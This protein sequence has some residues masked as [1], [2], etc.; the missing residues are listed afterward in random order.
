V[1]HSEIYRP[2]HTL[3]EAVA[4]ERSEDIALVC[5]EVS[6]SYA[7]LNRRANRLAH[8]LRGLGI[9]SGMTIG[10]CL[11]RSI[12]MV[13]GMLGILKAGAAYLPLDQSF[14]LERLSFMLDDA[15]PAA[16]V[17]LSALES[18]LP[19]WWGQVVCLDEDIPAIDAC[20]PENPT[21]EV[22]PES[23][24]NVIYT[25][26]SSGQPKGSLIPHRS[27]PG[28][29]L[30]VDYAR[31]DEQTVLLHYSSISWDAGTFEIWCPL[32]NGGKCVLMPYSAQFTPA[33]MAAALRQHSVNTLFLTNAVF[34]LLV[35]MLPD[36]LAG[37]DQ[38]L[39]GGEVMSMLHL[40]KYRQ[41]FPGTV[42]RHVYGPSECTVFSTAW[43]V[44]P[45]IPESATSIPIGRPV[46]DRKVY[47][48]DANLRRVPVGVPGELCIAGPAVA[49]GYLNRPDQT[50]AH[51]VPN[52][53][54][55]GTYG[56]LYRSGDRARLLADGVIDFL[57]RADRQVK[58]RGFR[59]E[60]DEV[61]HALTSHPA[62]REAAV[63]LREDRPGDKRLIAYFSP[64]INY[65]LA[66]DDR[67]LVGR[68]IEGWASIF[69]EHIYT[70]HS[71]AVDPLFNTTGWISNH[72]NS[73][74]PEDHMRAWA[75]DIVD[76][77][78]ANSPAAVLELG[79]GTGML[80]FR[81]APHTRSYTGYDIS[82]ACLD[83]IRRQNPP[84]QV[85]LV[86]SAA[87]ELDGI[88]P[89][90]LDLVILSS[91]VQ[92]FPGAEY[93]REVID[94][95]LELLRPGG[96]ILLADLR[97]FDWLEHF[98]A[99]V[100]VHQAQSDATSGA[101]RKAVHS[102]ISRETE[103]VVSPAFFAEHWPSSTHVFL[104]R[105][106]FSNEL[107]RFRF[108][109]I[110]YKGAAPATG[111]IQE[112]DA[113]PKERLRA[114]ELILDLLE[115][116]PEMNA[117]ELR[118]QAYA[119]APQPVLDNGIYVVRPRPG[120][121]TTN[122]PLRTHA[123]P[124]IIHE[125]RRSLA[126]VMPDFM[127]PSAFVPMEALPRNASGKVDFAAL[128]DPAF[129]R[130]AGH[131]KYAA[132]RG[133]LEQLIAN[134]YAALLN[135]ERA[136]RNDNFFDLGGHSLLATQLTSRLRELLRTDVPL[137]KIFER[138][139]VAGLA[140]WL[141]ANEAKPGMMAAVAALRLKLEAMPE[142]EAR[143][144]LSARMADAPSQKL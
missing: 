87:H 92:Y 24:F 77:A 95:C 28:V 4:S 47:I 86:R 37:V 61:E 139:T 117:A 31:F 116:C 48:L 75:D 41:N 3:F 38:L 9:D 85:Q 10:L 81:I 43:E 130:S 93:L 46:G 13:V 63:I 133:D 58:L 131:G 94:R 27:V 52:P 143:Q 111:N 35:D 53:F 103:L 110:I 141:T 101:I 1:T 84:A 33:E 34:N 102:T 22:T 80:L 112:V 26:G 122:A 67:E 74:I 100:Q 142:T 40:R 88:A 32:L 107:N 104:E 99:S 25:S 15:S 136:G 123:A 59:I 108:H 42:L 29:M 91:V 66:D 118:T 14:P 83:Y 2:V 137:R 105:N 51:F 64:D 109:A 55:T 65:R 54:A 36:A 132:P 76:H 50:E 7:E 135:L 18:R 82:S 68:H 124:A 125:L 30:N 39:V 90:S 126:E 8:Y 44:P 20:P 119:P 49:L 106:T 71:R 115:R 138:P 79:C 129:A 140:E 23:L 144:L 62:V 17:T 12:D 60:L 56:T 127:V 96:R 113:L 21:I 134:T 5:G 57:G 98:H 89:G 11:P 120:V 97:N 121:F 78:L 16:I 114:E 70:P 128:P 6:I 72:D 73:P 45:A 19:T 69:D